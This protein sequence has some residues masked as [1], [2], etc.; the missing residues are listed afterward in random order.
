M[1]TRANLRRLDALNLI[2]AIGQQN[3]EA[4]REVLALYWDDSHA[5]IESMAFVVSILLKNMQFGDLFVAQMREMLL[6]DEAQS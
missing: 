5:L 4:A 2:V 1:I 3:H 6:S